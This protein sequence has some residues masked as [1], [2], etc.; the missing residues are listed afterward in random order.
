MNQIKSGTFADNLKLP[1]NRWF[2]FSAGFSAAWVA[3][4]IKEKNARKVLDPFVG[5]GTTLIAA[6]SIGIPSVGYESH[7]FIQRIAE[8]KISW[9]FDTVKFN[10]LI[11]SFIKIARSYNDSEIDD[12]T[13]DRLLGKMYSKE[14]LNSLERLRK[15]Y[16]SLIE[17]NEANTDKEHKLIWLGITSILRTSSYAGTAPWQYLLPNKRK[18]SVKEPFT[19]F[20]EF[21]NIVLED[22][23]ETKY[24]SWE[25]NSK[26]ILHDVREEI[27]LEN[28]FD[29]LITSPP[30]P[31]NYDYADSTRLEMTYW[32]EISGWKDLQ[33]VVRKNLL[34]SCSQHS[35]A[36][37]LDLKF[38]LSQPEIQPLSTEINEVCEKLAEIR[39]TRGGKKTYHTMVAAYFYDLAKIFINLRPL[40]TESSL[41]CFVIGDSAPYGIHVPVEKWLGKLAIAAGFKDYEFEKLR[42]RNIKWDNRVHKLPLHEGNLWIKG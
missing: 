31:N 17:N 18:S 9:D 25:K 4:V 7:P 22:R 33:P 10:Q 39:L 5:S 6:D 30:Y 15:A 35:A 13:N 24:G 16:F 23:F 34:R 32:G 38:L 19:A 11:K 40:M 12:R 41:L 21:C 3:S 37:K 29:L 36:E 26:V 1:V 8:A 20:N 27:P 28:T 2:R 14:A 42:D